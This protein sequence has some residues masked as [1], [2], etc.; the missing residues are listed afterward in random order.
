MSYSY[1]VSVDQQFAFE[2]DKNQIDAA[3]ILLVAP[4]Q[5]HGISDF[6]SVNATVIS[7]HFNE[8]KYVVQ[9]QG[10][11]FEVRIKDDLDALIDEMGFSI[12]ATKQVNEIKAP[13]PGLI[14]DIAIEIGQSVDENQMLLILEAMKME[15]TLL[16]PR[17]GIIK[18]IEV[19]KGQAVEK[20]QILI[21]FE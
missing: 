3:D 17:S 7:S 12:S 9:I 18:S 8:K 15:N 21:T 5:Y 13:M 4:N 11:D 16:S 2:L 1:K 14:L 20:G 10:T 19:N 6:R